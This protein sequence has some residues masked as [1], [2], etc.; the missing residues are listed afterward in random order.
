M[1][2]NKFPFYITNSILIY[3]DLTWVGVSRLEGPSCGLEYFGPAG[4][5]CCD[6]A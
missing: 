5:G 1:E 2:V 3:N 4:T 6:A